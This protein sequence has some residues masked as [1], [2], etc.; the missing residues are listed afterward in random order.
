M[1]CHGQATKNVTEKITGKLKFLQMQMGQNF[2]SFFC[3]H[4]NSRT[5][6]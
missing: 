2:S 4:V 5:A 3:R 1:K 6:I